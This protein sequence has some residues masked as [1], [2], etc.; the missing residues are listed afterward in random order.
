ML[1]NLAHLT[2]RLVVD[3]GAIDNLPMEKVFAYKRLS[4]AGA[5]A[6]VVAIFAFMESRCGNN[7]SIA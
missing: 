7:G 5:D 4:C 6:V 2:P 1:G 3:N